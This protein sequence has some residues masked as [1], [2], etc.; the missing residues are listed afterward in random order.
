MKNVHEVKL[1]TTN[2]NH[3]AA[4][5]SSDHQLE[6]ASSGTDVHTSLHKLQ[7]HQIEQ[8]TQNKSPQ[9]PSTKDEVRFSEFFDFSPSSLLSLRHDGGIDVINLAGAGL[10]GAE[11]ASLIGRSLGDFV[12]PE[13]RSVF[14]AH[15]REV[16]ASQVKSACEIVFI[17]ADR[18]SPIVYIESIADGSGRTCRMS[19]VEITER[20][21]MENAL[22]FVVQ[23]GWA[24][25]AGNVF[26]TLAQY[27]AEI[28]GVDYVSIAKLAGAPDTV[29]TVAFYAKGK[30]MPN[31]AYALKGTPCSNV[32]DRSLC[33]YP[34]GIQSLFPDDIMLVDLGVEGYAGISLWDSTGQSIGLIAVMDSKPLLSES[35]ITQTL[36]LVAT[37]ASA[38]LERMR[39]D[40]MLQ[41]REREFHTLAENT[42]NII[43]RYDRGYRCTYVNPAFE[44][45]TGI[46]AK[47]AKNIAPDVQWG[48]GMPI[49]EYQAKLQQVMDTGVVEQLRT[50]WLAQDGGK[51]VSYEINIVPE[52]G[53][54]DVAVGALV[55]GHN[56]STLLDTER[57]LEES[58]TQLHELAV[59]RGDV[60][61]EE[62][63]RIARD[64][65]DELGQQLTALRLDVSLVRMKFGQDNPPLVAYIQKITGRVDDT[66][67][68]IRNVAS[69]LRPA[70]LDIGIVSALE[71][72]TKEFVRKSGLHCELNLC[73]EQVDLDEER[74]TAIFRIVQESLTNIARHAKAKKVEI[75]LQQEGGHYLLEVRD[76]GQGY[77][78]NAIDKK[79][80]GL[81]GIQERVLML[82][83]EL[84]ISSA[85]GAGTVVKVCIPV[86]AVSGK[87]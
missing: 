35:S 59:R 27:L 12:A 63:K 21:H 74:A 81:I 20:K 51:T 86:Q 29:E 48:A 83:G 3:L 31:I 22:R 71:W 78:P 79:T 2:Q 40:C 5:P 10:L 72:Q 53:V 54:G 43:V 41:A 34:Q 64:L 8:E 49:A 67:Q 25:D 73:E 70:V 52:Y 23:R 6:N 65:H 68:M 28:L 87:S 38:E 57:R 61:E 17:T 37:R 4:L 26:A 9:L 13:Y 16:F 85:P 18:R 19:L 14:D 58:R 32:M 62:R 39:S 66:I 45:E 44:R 69:K 56:I 76:D 60:C 84:S 50:E 24:S 47:Q 55:I 33:Y 36:K 7:I 46:A 1:K 15:M 42:P 80:F 11:R 82:K 77:N 75:S 30:I